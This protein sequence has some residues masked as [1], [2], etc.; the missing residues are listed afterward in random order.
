MKRIL[1]TG[2]NRGLGLE[3]VRQGLERGEQIFAGVRKISSPGELAKL[4]EIF[5]QQLSLIELD[6][7]DETS[8]LQ[9]RKQIEELTDGLE[10]LVNNA[11]IFPRGETPRSLDANTL[12]LAYHTNAVAPLI[13][14]QH[15]L[16]LLKN[17]RQAK[18]INVTSQMGSIE[19]KKYGGNYSY[20]GSK[21]AL[22]MFT[23]TLA[24]DLKAE[25]I[26]VVTLHPGWVQTDMGGTNA[27]LEPNESIKSILDL[28]SRLTIEDSGK[29]LDWEGDELPW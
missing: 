6:V 5:P 12:L 9:A 18:I 27:P 20:S 28:V 3:F 19:R 26:T 8:I 23:K 1:I 24:H 25:G 7:T 4:T 10:V 14:V 17:G 29:F 22:N 21:A 15:F 2:T 16:E 11:G 13:V